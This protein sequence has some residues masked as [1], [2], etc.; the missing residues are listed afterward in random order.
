MTIRVYTEGN[1]TPETWTQDANCATTDPE[2]WFP[3]EGDP[4]TGTRAKQFCGTCNVQAACLEY[5]VR[6]NQTHGIWGGLTSRQI[7]RLRSTA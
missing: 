5:A 2:L 7:R 1:L 6:T 4:A 3:D